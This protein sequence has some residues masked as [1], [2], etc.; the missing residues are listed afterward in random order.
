MLADTRA[1]VNGK[2]LLIEVGSFGREM[3]RNDQVKNSIRNLVSQISGIDCRLGPYTPSGA[4]QYTSNENNSSGD[5][6]ASFAEKIMK[7][8]QEAGIDVEED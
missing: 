7:R 2:Y 3:L 6:P 5:S 8:A 1:F 4:V